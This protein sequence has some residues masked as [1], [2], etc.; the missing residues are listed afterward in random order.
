[1]S[2]LTLGPFV[3]AARDVYRE[4]DRPPLPNGWTLFMDC[5]AEYQNDGYFGAAYRK[6]AISISEVEI[7]IAHRGTSNINDAIEDYGMVFQSEV[8]KQ[9]YSSAVPF[10]EQ[11]F[12]AIDSEFSD[13]QSYTN[14]YFY[15]TGHSL[16][17]TL[18]ELSN[19]RYTNYYRD[20]GAAHKIIYGAYAFDSP[21]SYELVQVQ[22][23]Q[24]EV[25]Q[26][27]FDRAKKYTYVYNADIDAI[28]TSMTPITK[29]IYSSVGFNYTSLEGVTAIVP[30]EPTE[31]FYSLVYTINDQHKIVNIYNYIY[32]GGHYTQ[33]ENSSWPLGT[34]QGYVSYRTYY[35]TSYNVPS[36][37]YQHNQY[38]NLYT[39]VYWDNNPDIHSLYS[40]SLETFRS[41]YYQNV[42]Y[43]YD[44]TVI[45][46]EISNS[47][48]KAVVISDS[49]AEQE[50][51]EKA[52]ER[53]CCGFTFFD[54]VQ[55]SASSAADTVGRIVTET[56]EELS[57]VV[58]TANSNYHQGRQMFFAQVDEF[59]NGGVS[60]LSPSSKNH[61]VFGFKK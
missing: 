4:K 10:I 50:A 2:V 16:G 47:P 58:S 11:V 51:K 13:K 37:S 35:G 33:V 31:A 36:S 22:L 52:K 39:K 12:A 46:K 59:V 28:N 45:P 53:S 54:G 18:S 23:D 43:Y 1:M 55:K 61:M 44:G 26:E 19:V 49:N 32:S 38:W 21:G 60:G 14:V 9:F 25:S 8:P 29:Y 15:F 27:D 34:T 3:S 20:R 42:L 7:I 41:Y 56:G 30:Y 57:Q 17:A 24:N 48:I 40:D 6:D 5:P